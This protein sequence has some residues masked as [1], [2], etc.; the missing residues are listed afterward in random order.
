MFY[1]RLDLL[2]N[3]QEIAS[4]FTCPEPGQN[5]YINE[6]TGQVAFSQ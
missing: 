1:K 3:P 5:D 2:S 4:S 6:Q